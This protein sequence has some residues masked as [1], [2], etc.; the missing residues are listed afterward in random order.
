MRGDLASIATRASEIEQGSVPV[1]Q[2][3]ADFQAP[4]VAEE[5][6][7]EQSWLKKHAR[8]LVVLGLI[9]LAAAAGAIFIAFVLPALRGSS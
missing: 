2:Q 9:A 3:A 1:P 6:T 7:R 5:D 4:F 8:L